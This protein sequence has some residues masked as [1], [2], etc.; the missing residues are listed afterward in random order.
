MLWIRIFILDNLSARHRCLPERN[1]F[2]PL[3]IIFHGRSRWSLLEQ[4]AKRNHR[5]L[6]RGV[7]NMQLAP[8]HAEDCT[9]PSPAR[10]SYDRYDS[11]Q[12]VPDWHNLFNTFFARWGHIAKEK[13]MLHR[14]SGSLRGCAVAAHTWRPTASNSV[15]GN[16]ITVGIAARLSRDSPI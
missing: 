10:E 16:S 3:P 11:R 8:R 7:C 5:T 1:Q 6:S 4:N 9:K 13:E 12:R 2:P 15:A 14:L